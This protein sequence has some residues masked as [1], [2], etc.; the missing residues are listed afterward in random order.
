M[1]QHRAVTPA[2]IGRGEVKTERLEARTTK[3]L[4]ELFQ[5]AADLRGQSLTDFMISALHDLS[6]EVIQ[7]HEVITLTGRNREVFLEALENPKPLHPRLST[8]MSRLE[9]LKNGTRT[10]RPSASRGKKRASTAR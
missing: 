8:A 2:D 7:A 6:V 9:E 10:F 5:R 3:E 1:S 4:K